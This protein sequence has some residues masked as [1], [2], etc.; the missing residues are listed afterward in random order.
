M[1]EPATGTV[2]PSD[3]YGFAERLTE[4]ERRVIADL[5]DALETTVAPL[6][7]EAWDLSLIHI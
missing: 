1:R 4:A 3:L 5:R 2:I 6:L 7:N